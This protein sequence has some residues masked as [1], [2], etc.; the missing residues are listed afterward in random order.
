M[1]HGRKLGFTVSIRKGERLISPHR[2]VTYAVERGHGFTNRD[3]PVALWHFDH[4]SQRTVRCPP[5]LWEHGIAGCIMK[6]GRDG[7]MDGTLDDY[8]F[9]ASSTPSR[10]CHFTFLP[11][12]PLSSCSVFVFD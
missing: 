3:C 12:K 1:T 7:K 6:S 9:C 4:G 11:G 5:S 2:D 10:R 8:L